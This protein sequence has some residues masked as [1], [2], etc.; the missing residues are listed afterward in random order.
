MG[1]EGTIVELDE[2]L[3]GKKRKHGRGGSTV[4]VWVLG[5]IERQSG[6]ILTVP[7]P[8]RKRATLLW[9]DNFL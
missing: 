9:N 4:Q 3:F 1:G 7:V 6:R 8:D 2:S 5:L